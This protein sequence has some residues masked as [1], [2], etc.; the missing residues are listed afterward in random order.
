MPCFATA[1]YILTLLVYGVQDELKTVYDVDNVPVKGSM[2]S[3][4]AEADVF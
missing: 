2:N 3:C 4:P 1:S